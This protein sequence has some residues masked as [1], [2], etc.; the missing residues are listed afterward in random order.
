MILLRKVAVV[1]FLLINDNH[2]PVHDNEEL[3]NHFSEHFS[4]IS[5]NLPYKLPNPTTY[6]SDYFSD[7]NRESIYFY[8]TFFTKINCDRWHEI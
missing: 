2:V 8:T 3:A 7:A 5:Q 6:C 1:N 4:A